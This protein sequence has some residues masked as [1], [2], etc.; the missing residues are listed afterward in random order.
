MAA[1]DTTPHCMDVPLLS[2]PLLRH[3]STPRTLEIDLKT[4]LALRTAIQTVPLCL[5]IG[6]ASAAP[7]ISPSSFERA[8]GEL[9]SYCI[10]RMCLGSTPDAVSKLG[11]IKWEQSKLP[12]GALT[13]SDYLFGN[14]AAGQLVASDGTEFEVRFELVSTSGTP[15]SRYRLTSAAI[16]LPKITSLQADHLI[17]SLRSRVGATTKGAS[18][19]KQFR[20]G[21]EKRSEDVLQAGWLIVLSGDFLFK[22][23]WLLTQQK[24]RTGLPTL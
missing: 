23:Q 6:S 2:Q 19:T 17:E 10:E 12:T 14:H 22:N 5:L 1:L 13:C 7:D 11:E 8:T 9:K 4:Y 20:I 18:I 16:K 15:I 21:V 3:N 24:C